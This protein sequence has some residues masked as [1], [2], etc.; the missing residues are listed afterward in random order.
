[1]ST[2]AVGWTTVS[3]KVQAEMLAN[4]LIVGKW[5]ACA[6]ISGP[7]TSIYTWEGKI[8][9]AEEYRIT[10]KFPLDKLKALEQYIH[11]NHPYDTP[12]WVWLTLDG[13]SPDYEKW[14]NDVT[15]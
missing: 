5:A 10:L 9:R 3:N 7:M 13:S 12:Q 8:E 14:V 1:M 11:E 4:A 15:T 6:Q 2:I